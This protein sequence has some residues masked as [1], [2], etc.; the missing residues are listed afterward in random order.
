[1][2]EIGLDGASVVA[3]DSERVSKLWEWQGWTALGH[4]V[5]AEIVLS[6]TSDLP[7]DR[8]T[9]R[10]VAGIPKGM[11]APR[12][13]VMRGFNRTAYMCASIEPILSG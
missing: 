12:R 7:N 8:Y 4:W 3:V 2:A 1:M 11:R 13:I 5:N 10:S 6:I 9:P